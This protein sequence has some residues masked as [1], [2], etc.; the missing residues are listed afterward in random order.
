MWPLGDGIGRVAAEGG[1]CF[2]VNFDYSFYPPACATAIRQLLRLRISQGG[3]RRIAPS[4]YN[5]IREFS[6]DQKPIGPGNA[7]TIRPLLL[8]YFK[9][10]FIFGLKRSLRREVLI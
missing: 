1:R 8:G 10:K 2:V 6:F 3:A 4:L 9:K 5:D 7:E